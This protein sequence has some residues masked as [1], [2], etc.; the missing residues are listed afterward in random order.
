LKLWRTSTRKYTSLPSEGLK[1]APTGRAQCSKSLRWVY[2]E[3]PATIIDRVK[4]KAGELERLI[5]RLADDQPKYSQFAVVALKEAQIWSGNKGRSDKR[6]RSN[7]YALSA[8]SPPASRR[9]PRHGT[10][11]C[12]SKTKRRPRKAFGFSCAMSAAVAMTASTSIS[13][14]RVGVI[15]HVSKCRAKTAR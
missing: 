12:G 7:A 2:V 3:S 4:T 9:E 14:L 8:G 6:R 13:T 10:P 11:E 1:R 5:W 15:T